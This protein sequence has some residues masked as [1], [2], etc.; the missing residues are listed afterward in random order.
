MDLSGRK[1]GQNGSGEMSFGR[2][3][4]VPGYGYLA[5]HFHGGGINGLG[6]VSAQRNVPARK[7]E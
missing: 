2:N 7:R 4:P 5:Y 6:G 3:G 1:C